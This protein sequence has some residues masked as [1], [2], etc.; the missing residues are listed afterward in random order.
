[1]ALA[2]SLVRLVA[3][4]LVRLVAVS[5]RGLVR[6]VAVS[7]VAVSL[8]AWPVVHAYICGPSTWPRSL[9]RPVSVA[10]HATK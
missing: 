4:S 10:R 9:V 8:V 7:L 6:L 1:V 2:V 5:R 3:V